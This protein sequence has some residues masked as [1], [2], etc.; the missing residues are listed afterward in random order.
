MNKQEIELDN[1]FD[2]ELKE[3][4]E[5]NKNRDLILNNCICYCFIIYIFRY[6]L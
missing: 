1:D 3:N 5:I 6:I 4:I 2:N